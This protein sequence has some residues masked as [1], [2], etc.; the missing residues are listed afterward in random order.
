MKP[1]ATAMATATVTATTTATATATANQLCLRPTVSNS[2]E[3]MVPSIVAATSGEPLMS[4]SGGEVSITSLN[5]ITSA[6]TP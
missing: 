2:V 4:N 6:N 1:T 3:T 5:S